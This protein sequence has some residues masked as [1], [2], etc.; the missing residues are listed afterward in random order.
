M[1]GCSFEWYVGPWAGA[2]A[3]VGGGVGAGVGVDFGSW[4]FFGGAAGAL[5]GGAGFLGYWR[6][7]AAPAADRAG[8][9]AAEPIERGCGLV[10]RGL[11]DC[12]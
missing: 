9:E 6:R 5:G 10:L 7:V 11:E 3:R 2:G 1:E 8:F 12:L 4:I